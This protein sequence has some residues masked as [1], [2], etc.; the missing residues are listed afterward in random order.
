MFP[1]FDVASIVGLLIECQLARRKIHEKSHAPD[2]LLQLHMYDDMYLSVLFFTT[3]TFFDLAWNF[4]H[5]LRLDI[6]IMRVH[7]YRGPQ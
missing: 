3:S 4:S 6:L 5:A 7:L 1:T 2:L